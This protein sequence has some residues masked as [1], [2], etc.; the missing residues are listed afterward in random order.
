MEIFFLNMFSNVPSMKKDLVCKI[1]L[2][3]SKQAS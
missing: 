3:A 1:T 2:D